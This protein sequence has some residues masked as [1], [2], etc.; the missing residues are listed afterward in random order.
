MTRPWDNLREPEC[1]E[2]PVA[3]TG[4]DFNAV[5]WLFS[6]A[7][8]CKARALNQSLIGVTSACGVMKPQPIV[9]FALWVDMPD[10]DPLQPARSCGRRVFLRFRVG[11]R[12]LDLRYR[13]ENAWSQRHC[14]VT[15][16]RCT[17]GS[18]YCVSEMWRVY[19]A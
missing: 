9:N 11:N 2:K 4:V 3:S 19:D 15:D 12:Y 16:S 8:L 6:T 13:A 1:Y 7:N 10:T 17:Q 18:G 14:R 5:W